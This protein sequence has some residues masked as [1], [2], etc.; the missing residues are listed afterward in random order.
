[1]HNPDKIREFIE[2]RS[3]GESCDSI[4]SQ[5]G[6]SR[7][8]LFAWNKKYHAKI[9]RSAHEDSTDCQR[10]VIDDMANSIDYASTVQSQLGISIKH[11]FRD[12]HDLSI[13]RRINLWLKMQ[14]EI[15][16]MSAQH[17]KQMSDL[18]QHLK[19]FPE[20]Q[21]PDQFLDD[22]LSPSRA[23]DPGPD[24][25]PEEIAQMFENVR[26]NRSPALNPPP[27]VISPE[28]PKSPICPENPISHSAS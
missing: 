25:S 21:N 8:T 18:V 16:R 22:S 5:L 9:H 2:R 1:M 10:F 28:S 13:D 24:L 4:A 14:R 6:V 17:R 27:V 12:F 23:I 20:D 15:D 7:S 11:D 19:D 26:S 3:K